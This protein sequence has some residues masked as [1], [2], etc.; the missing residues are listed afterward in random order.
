MLQEEK[1][2]MWSNNVSKFVDTIENQ[3]LFMSML[4]INFYD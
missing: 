3:N 4:Y 2:F 1:V